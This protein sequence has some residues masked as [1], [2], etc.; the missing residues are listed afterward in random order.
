MSENLTCDPS[1]EEC[2]PEFLN[3]IELNYAT[4]SLIMG[5]LSI[6][7]AILPYMVY[8]RIFLADQTDAQKDALD[9]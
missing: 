7:N 6:V 5:A 3:T 9:S 2:E 1:I 4:P 8:K